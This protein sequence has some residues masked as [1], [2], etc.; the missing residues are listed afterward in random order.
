MREPEQVTGAPSPTVASEGRPRLDPAA[1]AGYAAGVG[2]VFVATLGVFWNY[3]DRSA[4]TL[5]WAGG[6]FL[7]GAVVGA[8][9]ALA[10]RGRA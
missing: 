8:V 10:R 4:A 3:W 9:W 1:I 6:S 5:T 7:I 2:A